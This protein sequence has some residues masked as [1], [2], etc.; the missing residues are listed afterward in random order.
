MNILIAVDLSDATAKI[1]ET[2]RSVLTHG[3]ARVWLL[4][5]AEPDPDFVGYRAG[6]DTV[7]DSVARKY[8]QEHAGIQ[9]LAQGLRDIGIEAKALLIQGSAPDVIL[10]HIRDLEI[11]L[12]IMGSHGKGIARQLLLGS[13]SE[14]V[15]HASTIPVLIVPVREQ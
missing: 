2:A 11:D 9:S 10:E 15:L 14:S 6:P 1:M 4:H 13:V 8:H 12:L 7:R 5:V 3:R